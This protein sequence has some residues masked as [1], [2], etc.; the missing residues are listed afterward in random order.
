MTRYIFIS[1]FFLA[2]FLFIIATTANSDYKAF[3][4]SVSH[5]SKAITTKATTDSPEMPMPALPAAATSE[6]ERKST[7]MKM[8]ELAHIHHFHKERVK[9]VKRHHKKIWTVSKVLLIIIH[10]VLLVTAFMHVTH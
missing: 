4:A 8:E 1:S 6:H 3:S 10:M 9:K 2:I 7:G 5:H